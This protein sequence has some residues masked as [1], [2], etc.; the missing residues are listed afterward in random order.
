MHEPDFVSTGV[1]SPHYGRNSYEIDRG[2]TIEALLPER[3]GRA[4]DLGCGPG[5]FSRMLQRRGWQVVGVD[6]EPANMT[7]A[8]QY[9]VATH[10]GDVRDVAAQLPPE[11][12]DL[13]CAFEIIEHMDKPD[14]VRLVSDMHRMLKPNGVCFL[15][16]PNKMS[17]EG[18]GHYYWGE[19]LRGWGRWD[20]WNPTHVHIYSSF[21]LVR[22]IKALGLVVDRVVG[23]WY[24]GRLPGG[25]SWRLPVIASSR[26]PMSHLGFN[27]I[28]QCHKP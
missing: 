18:L 8:R 4:L 14:G 5:Y 25:I 3:N 12:F 23:Y 22:Q 19:K 9:T 13:V 27:C 20:A 11:H 7:R 28:V 1:N 17:P 6:I 2:R 15:S 24:R 16:T 21:E 26:F 10:C